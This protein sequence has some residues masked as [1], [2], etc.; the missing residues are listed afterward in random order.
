MLLG[1]VSDERYVALP[2]VEVEIARPARLDG[3]SFAGSGSR[4]AD[5]EPGRL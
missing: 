1:Y 5:I 4:Y 3:D 2:G